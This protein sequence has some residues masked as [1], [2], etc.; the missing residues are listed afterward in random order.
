MRRIVAV[1]GVL[2]LVVSVAAFAGS[3]KRDE[4]A[5]K[6]QGELKKIDGRLKLSAD[7][8]TQVKTLLVE[9]SDKLDELYA[10]IEPREEAIRTEYRDKI[11]GVLTPEQQTEWDKI[12]SEYKAKWTGNKPDS[13]TSK[14]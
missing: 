2:A 1:F 7:Q 11:R 10:E 3:G 12:K 9:Q 6:V 13:K 5:K 14:K 4:V 8:K